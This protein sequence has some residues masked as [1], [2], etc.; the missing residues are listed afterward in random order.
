MN[1]RKLLRKAL[2]SPNNLRFGDLVTLI[3]AFG[4]RLARISGSHR[5][6]EHP[7]VAQLLNVQDRKGKGKAYQVR[8]F[9]ELV[10]VHNLQLGD[11]T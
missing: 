4:F 6:F 2:A 11:E 5:I 9:L 7:G 10:E 3:E 1:P 8:Q